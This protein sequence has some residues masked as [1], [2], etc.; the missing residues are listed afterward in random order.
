MILRNLVSY[1]INQNGQMKIA[2]CSSKIL[3]PARIKSF[4]DPIVST[5][6]QSLTES[7]TEQGILLSL[8][9]LNFYHRS[10]SKLIMQV[11]QLLKKMVN[12]EQGIHFILQEVLNYSLIK[13]L[14]LSFMRIQK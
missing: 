1:W 8:Q 12:Y 13:N 3:K 2:Q 9:I 6:S 5:I 4:S 7:R 11:I 14:I 10:P